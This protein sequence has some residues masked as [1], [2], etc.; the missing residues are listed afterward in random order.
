VN[1]R[2][3]IRHRSCVWSDINERYTHGTYPWGC[4]RHRVVEPYHSTMPTS[5]QQQAVHGMGMT[6]VW[7]QARPVVSVGTMQSL[8]RLF[9]SWCK[10]SDSQGRAW[11]LNTQPSQCMY[12]GWKDPLPTCYDVSSR[13]QQLISPPR[14]RRARLFF[15]SLLRVLTMRRLTE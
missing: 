6:R 7:N 15:L 12:D 1:V 13:E 8:P 11:S 3:M 9:S 4:Y 14:R 2:R 5:K 10:V